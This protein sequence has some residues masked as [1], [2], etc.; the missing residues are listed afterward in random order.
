MKYDVTYMQ[1]PQLVFEE[2]NVITPTGNATLAGEHKWEPIF[3]AF[4]NADEVYKYHIDQ[5]GGYFDIDFTMAGEERW[6]LTQCLLK[7][8]MI[9]NTER[10]LVSYAHARMMSIPA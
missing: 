3:I 1:R 2:I 5:G 7:S 6:V 8:R 9:P 4:E 10:F